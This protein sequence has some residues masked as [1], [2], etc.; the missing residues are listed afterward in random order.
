MKTYIKTEGYLNIINTVKHKTWFKGVEN[1]FVIY[2]E[3]IPLP[4]ITFMCTVKAHGTNAGLGYNPLTKEI[5]TLSK[6]AV[7]D[8]WTGHMGF[9]EWVYANLEYFTEYFE[10]IQ[11]DN[12]FSEI[13]YD[14]IVLYG[15]WAGG[16]IQ[17]KVAI[18]GLPKFF[19]A[20][21]ICLIKDGKTVGEPYKRIWVTDE[22]E[23]LLPFNESIR[24]F[25]TYCF[26]TYKVTIDFNDAKAGQI[27]L[28]TIV[29]DVENECPIGRYFGISGIGEGIVC[30]AMYK[31]EFLIFKSKGEEHKNTKGKEKT[32]NPIEIEKLNSIKEFVEYAVT[33]NRVIQAI[34]TI[35]EDRQPT[36]KDTGD[37]VKWVIQDVFKEEMDALVAN[38]LEGGDVKN[39]IGKETVAIFKA[40]LHENI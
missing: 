2:D 13:E 26:D 39:Q 14:E 36:M 20:Y 21:S 38:K 29:E 16:N 19:M 25:N 27:A 35:C 37:I 10:S 6:N 31:D 9:S 15:E 23:T 22:I 30:T 4:V 8:G 33:K 5:K 34:T 17:A 40:Y 32:F 12:Q 1:G 28:D 7:L 18:N 3:T 11:N 24:C